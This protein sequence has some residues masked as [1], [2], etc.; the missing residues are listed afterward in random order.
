MNNPSNDTQI[1]V[2]IKGFCVDSKVVAESRDIDKPSQTQPTNKYSLCLIQK[3]LRK[4]QNGEVLIQNIAI[5]LNPVDYKV[6]PYL[7]QGQIIGVDGV[8]IAI[9][10]KNPLIR[11]GQRYAYHAS[12]EQDGSFATYT[13]TQGRALIALDYA[14]PDEVAASLPCPALTS[15]Q[16]IDKIP[17]ASNKNVLIYGAGGAVGKI[18]VS[19]LILQ[20]AKVWAVASPKH[21]Q[22]LY[23]Q[24][25]IQCLDYTESTHEKFYAIFDTI[26]KAC[27]LLQSLKYYGHIIS[28]ADR[29]ERNPTKAFSTCPSFHEIALGAI[30]QYGSDEDFTRLQRNGAYLFDSV[31]KGEILLPPIKVIG[32]DEIPQALIQLQN[33]TQGVKFVANISNFG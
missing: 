15:L 7:A 24:G 22:V 1:P 27:D 20:G 31:L 3:P 23:K 8:G 2:N 33:N 28:I 26:G 13:I 18:L 14:M 32:F 29:V 30:Y 19:L 11:L 16:A 4:L 6:L 17:S 5:G 25:V 10:S 21:H 12:L 9:A